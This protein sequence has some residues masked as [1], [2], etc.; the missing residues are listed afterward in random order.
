MKILLI[1]D[2]GDITKMLSKY[3]TIKG[4]SCSVAND[5]QSGLSLIENQTF[6]V[7]ILDIAMPKFSG[8]DVI[9]ELCKSGKIKNQNIV[10]LTASILSGEVEST[11]KG[12]G[13]HSCLKKPIDPD[14]LLDHIK[15][16]ENKKTI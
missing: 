4:H 5:G 15:Q 6:D 10:T 7:I 16:F 13:V 12:K 8:S 11:L 9:D 1:D 14:I 3:M 2:N